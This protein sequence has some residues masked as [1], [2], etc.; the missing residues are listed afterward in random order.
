MNYLILGNGIAGITAAE[1]IR[2]LDDHGQITLISDETFSPYCRPMISHLLEGA[3][4]ISRLPVRGTDFYEKNKITPI[5]GARVDS[6]DTRTQTAVTKNGKSFF[7]DRLLIATGADPRPIDAQGLDLE[8]VF[9]MRNVEHVKKMIKTLPQVRHALVLGGGLVGFKAAYSL[10]RQKISVT[11]LIRSGYPL[12]MQVDET[13]GEIIR[14]S[15]EKN[16][17]T[18]KTGISVTAFEGKNKLQ[19]AHL[20]DNTS[21]DCQMCIIGKGV[22]PAHGF[23]PK[24]HIKTDAGILV[25]DC[26]QTSVPGIYAAGDVAEHI[27]IARNQRWVNAIWPEAVSQGTVAGF[28]MAG[29]KF[30]YRGSLSRNVIRIF[31]TDMMTA[32]MVSSR[33]K[34]DTLRVFSAR[35]KKRG[36]YRKLI[37]KNHILVGFVMIN[38]IEQ[39]GVLMSLIQSRRPVDTEKL[40]LTDPAFNV[41]RLMG[42]LIR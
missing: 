36:T 16:G 35:D 12:S 4:D 14:R 37:F 5:L 33:E 39:G 26:M 41:G 28:N 8:G 9:F 2:Q 3:V 10:L 31:D 7:Y 22:F 32:G 25:D 40:Q 18:V 21:I 6:I 29:H 19:A 11:M 23:I 1:T 38:H 42:R 13:A 24:D 34:D 30:T 27:D 20:S 17:L 15:L